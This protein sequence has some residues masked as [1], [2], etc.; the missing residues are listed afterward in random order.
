MAAKTEPGLWPTRH[1]FSSILLM[2]LFTGACVNPPDQAIG[3]LQRLV[4]KIKAGEVAEVWVELGFAAQEPLQ[5]S[6]PDFVL[7]AREFMPQD[8]SLRYGDGEV[9]SFG[10]PLYGGLKDDTGCLA[11]LVAGDVVAWLHFT[12]GWFADSMETTTEELEAEFLRLYTERGGT[13]AKREWTQMLE[14]GPIYTIDFGGVLLRM[15]TAEE[16]RIHKGRSRF[17]VARSSAVLDELIQR[18]RE[19][20]PALYAHAREDHAATLGQ[21]LRMVREQGASGILMNY[22]FSGFTFK[23]GFAR[24]ADWWRYEVSA[25]YT[26]NEDGT[27]IN[28][29][30]FLGT[31]DDGTWMWMTFTDR[32][33]ER[34]NGI[35]VEELSGDF[36]ELMSTQG[37]GR[38]RIDSL[39]DEFDL[40]F[41]HFKYEQLYVTRKQYDHPQPGGASTWYTITVT[42]EGGEDKYADCRSDPMW[43][44]DLT[45]PEPSTPSGPLELLVRRIAG[46]SIP[47]MMEAFDMERNIGK[48]IPNFAATNV[49]YTELSLYF[50]VHAGSDSEICT[51]V[52]NDRTFFTNLM[53]NEE[54]ATRALG[55]SVDELRVEFDAM[56]QWFESTEKESPTGN[57][58]ATHTFISYGDMELRRALVTHLDRDDFVTYWIAPANP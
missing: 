56:A 14:S 53:F 47:Q 16:A 22:D 27:A 25:G 15:H 8:Y 52:A 58:H 38:C 49:P 40:N 39:H 1:V 57:G 11:Y 20:Y 24:Y 54:W 5:A 9:I 30:C 33:Y 19:K 18:K 10:M 7:G 29:D 28:T 41:S 50:R 43:P 31:R 32:W 48:S 37:G 3:P 6:P 45:L 2:L 17:D 21:L 26:T 34:A 44:G 13:K 23:E 35:S 55:I 4:H 36:D 46:S 51:L 12:A 42:E